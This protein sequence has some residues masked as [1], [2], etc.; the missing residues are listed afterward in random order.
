MYLL[1]VLEDEPLWEDWPADLPA[2]P[3]ESDQLSVQPPDPRVN[4][5]V[6][7]SP[8]YTVLSSVC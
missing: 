4:V 5:L 2:V 7:E 3:G 6:I 1:K 8:G